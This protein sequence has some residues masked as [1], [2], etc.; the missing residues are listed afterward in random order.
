MSGA[1]MVLGEPF[2]PSPNVE[3]EAVD[4]SR[5]TVIIPALNEEA[6]LPL[7]LRSLP[8]V[9]EVIVVD[10]G[11][12]DR[13][14]E[15][16][17]SHGA[18]VLAEPRRGYGAACLRGL[19]AIREATLVGEEPPEIVAFVDGDYYWSIMEISAVERAPS[20]SG[21]RSRASLGSEF[22]GNRPL[23]IICSICFAQCGHCF[24]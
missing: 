20:Q 9:G 15:A 4:L 5:V 21:V 23:W 24:R 1:A 17:S 19:A 22:F 10:N 18:T 7:V 6:S 16:A 3:P 12:S 14:A 8:A 11:S 13:T 2:I